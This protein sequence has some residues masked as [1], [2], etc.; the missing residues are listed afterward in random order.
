MPLLLYK[1]TWPRLHHAPR[2][3]LAAPTGKSTSKLLAGRPFRL[4]LEQHG[5]SK[6][7]TLPDLCAQ[8]AR[9]SGD[10]NS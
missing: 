9:L 6:R 3:R 4:S 1:N 8:A 7:E 5:A 2:A 10:G